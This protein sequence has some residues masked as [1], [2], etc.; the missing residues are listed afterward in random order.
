MVR[1]RGMTNY[2]WFSLEHRAGQKDGF[3]I[4]DANRILFWPT[5]AAPGHVIDKDTAVKL[6]NVRRKSSSWIYIFVIPGVLIYPLSQWF[7]HMAY[8]DLQ[9]HFSRDGLFLGFIGLQLMALLILLFLLDHLLSSPKKRARI[10]ELLSASAQIHEPRPPAQHLKPSN[11]PGSS[12][13]KYWLVVVGFL[14]AGAGLLYWALPPEKLIGDQVLKIVPGMTLLFLAALLAY[15]EM[16][17]VTEHDIRLHP[18]SS[19]QE[20]NILTE[21]LD[22]AQASPVSRETLNAQA[23]K[24]N[25]LP[26]FLKWSF[27]GWRHYVIAWPMLIALVFGVAMTFQG[28]RETPITKEE[29]AERFMTAAAG[30]QH[31]PDKPFVVRKWHRDVTAFITPDGGRLAE[32]AAELLERYAS[33]A[34][35][36]VTITHDPN[37]RVNM[38]LVFR[39]GGK[40]PDFMR[41]SE[42]YWHFASRDDKNGRLVSL[43]SDIDVEVLFETTHHTYFGDARA[44]G[45]LFDRVAERIVQRA[46]GL[47]SD[48]EKGATDKTD[49]SGERIWFPRTLIAMYYDHRVI[50]GASHSELR[51]MAD[52]LA[53]EILAAPSFEDWLENRNR[54]PGHRAV[55]EQRYGEALQ[56]FMDDGDLGDPVTQYRIG[57]LYEMGQGTERDDVKAAEW[58]RKSAEQGYALAQNELGRLL[59]SGKTGKKERAQAVVWYERA[60]EK[61]LSAAQSNLCTIYYKG[62][63]VAQDIG[64]AFEHCR[65]AAQYGHGIAQDTL[66]LYHLKGINVE[67]SDEEA[68]KWFERAHKNTSAIGT[69][70]LAECYRTGRGREKN[71]YMAYRLYK[72]AQKAKIKAATT[73]LKKL[74]RFEPGYKERNSAG[75]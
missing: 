33:Y 25:I 69:Y 73:R 44:E 3:F 37:D 58:F 11:K 16:S 64:K 26:R 46:W 61:K 30:N 63:G 56:L 6:V 68:C 53:S 35:L 40:I 50:P 36:K 42:H 67:Q 21:G 48:Y 1:V 54:D 22:A 72:Q 20:H 18:S 10:A 23:D 57:W 55:Y 71:E 15:V 29:L 59:F 41:S 43:H 45:K 12:P 62:L 13:V 4:D 49:A 60:A 66:G 70:H 7:G 28:L 24:H 9:H 74:K 19:I 8:A 27:T 32:R 65:T 75:R 31:D 14:A 17:G 39:E 5:K 34:N 51:A 2:G 38:R 47:S 52:I